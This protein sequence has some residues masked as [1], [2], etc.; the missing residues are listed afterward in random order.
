MPLR[1]SGK[2]RSRST[3][4]VKSRCRYGRKKS[5]RRGCKSRPGPKRRS[6][7]RRSVKKRSRRRYSYNMN[8][9]EQVL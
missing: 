7:R 1:K 5:M 4:R 3:K 2:R 8:R 9:A 6:R